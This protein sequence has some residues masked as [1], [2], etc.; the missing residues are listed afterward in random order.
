M[1]KVRDNKDAPRYFYEL[2]SLRG[3]AA[4]TVVLLHFCLGFPRLWLSH[5]SLL[6]PFRLIF[7]GHQAVVLFFVLSGFVLTLPALR[8]KQPSYPVFLVKRLLRIYLPYLGALGLALACDFFFHGPARSGLSYPTEWANLTW[9]SP[10]TGRL[11]LEQ[12]LFLGNYPWAQVNTAFWSLVFELRISLIFP[13]LL[14]AVLTLRQR[15]VLLIGIACTLICFPIALLASRY[16]HPSTD[17]RFYYQTVITIHYMMMFLFGSLLAATLEKISAWYEKANRW[18]IGLCIMAMLLFYDGH[19]MERLFA[20]LFS[21]QGHQEKFFFYDQPADWSSMVGSLLLI[22]IAIHFMP[23]RNLLRSRLIHYLGKIS[24]SLYLVH[25]TVLFAMMHLFR[26][27]TPIPVL[28]GIYLIVTL[29]MTI[30]FYHGVEVP[31]IHA[32]KRAGSH[33]SEHRT[34]AA[35]VAS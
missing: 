21:L 31:A 13:L 3:V 25:G 7:A 22:V 30:A 23:L 16:G 14:V 15:W 26:L 28:L 5:L 2:D 6:F 33:R 4:F 11:L 19:L 32:S 27:E 24:F 8:G 9:T 20:I 10:I 12:I 1:T 29:M 34:V 17:P 18:Q 35:S